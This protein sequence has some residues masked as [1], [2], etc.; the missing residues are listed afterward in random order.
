MDNPGRTI[1]SMPTCGYRSISSHC[2]KWEVLEDS[3]C[4]KWGFL[5]LSLFSP[6]IECS[7]IRLCGLWAYRADVMWLIL[8]ISYWSCSIVSVRVLSSFWRHWH[9]LFAIVS[10]YRMFPYFHDATSLSCFKGEPPWIRLLSSLLP[11]TP[12][13]CNF[14]ARG[15]W[16][17]AS[18]AQY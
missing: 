3:K 1:I 12:P 10:L 13:K 7:I 15:V 9:Q 6:R 17:R 14:S 2:I 11:S 5:F 4:L 8:R 16:R 18:Y